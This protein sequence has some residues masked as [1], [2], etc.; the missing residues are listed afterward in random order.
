ME[1]ISVNIGVSRNQPKGNEIEITGIHKL[2][3][4]GATRVTAEGVADD[5]I[6]DLKNHGGP[7]QAAYIYSADD[8]AWWSRSLGREL[9]PGTFGDNLTI[10]GLDST[11]LR[12]GDRLKAGSVTLEVTA[13]RIPCSTLARRMADRA[14]IEKFRQAERPGAYC[15]VIQEGTLGRGD[16]VSLEA[17]DGEPVTILELFRERYRRDKEETRLRRY[18][19]APLSERTRGKLLE[20]LQGL[21]ETAAAEE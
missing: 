17:F 13:P 5:F 6:G 19:R 8:Y 4:T 7:D 18:L 15:R 12:I 2:A 16:A 11:R 20:N 3:A 14:F 9:G 1:I 10:S 21:A